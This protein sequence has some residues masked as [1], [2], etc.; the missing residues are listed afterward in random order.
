ML[1]KVGGLD[2]MS[3]RARLTSREILRVGC[4]L[5]LVVACASPSTATRTAAPAPAGELDTL[6]A[7]K[8]LVVSVRV[9]EPPS[10][11]VPQDPAHKQ[12]RAF[13]AAV[14]ELLA[15]RI[16][17][18]GAKVE[19][20]SAGGDRIA[21][22][23]SPGVDIAMVASSPANAARALLSTPYAAGAIVVAVPAAS[24]VTKLEELSGKTVAVAQDELRAPDLTSQAFQQ[25][26]IQVT[27]RTV[28]GMGGAS[29]L[30]ASGEAAAVV[31]DQ[32]GLAVLLAERPGSFRFIGELEKRPFVVA[33]RSGARELI[34]AVNGAL[35]DLL[36]SGAISAAATRAG[37]P[38]SAP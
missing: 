5:A 26:A 12:K 20:R 11:K 22:L 32:T 37:L 8:I 16:I 27:T 35:R 36:A 34:A 4:L 3:R 2:P 19:L 28:L 15:Q 23:D 38:Y 1:E 29:E 6:R 31:G 17:G 24:T 9:E 30:A 21:A 25:R 7:R 33:A 18:A 10:G 13:E 14:A